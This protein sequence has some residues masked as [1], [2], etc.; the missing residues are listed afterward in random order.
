MADVLEL[1]I[2]ERDRLDQAI[3]VL[4]GSPRRGWPFHRGAMKNSLPTA[5]GDGHGSVSF[6]R[7]QLVDEAAAYVGKAEV[8]ALIAEG[9]LGVI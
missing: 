9:E 1:L 7:Q 2:A 5:P 8:A 4:Q 6:S 3:A